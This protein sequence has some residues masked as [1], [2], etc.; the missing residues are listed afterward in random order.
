MGVFAV[1]LS[2]VLAELFTVRAD[3]PFFQGNVLPMFA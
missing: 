3:S 2:L 1:G